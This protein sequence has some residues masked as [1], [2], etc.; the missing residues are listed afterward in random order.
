[1]P[2]GITTSVKSR[3]MCSR[4]PAAGPAH[5]A[6]FGCLAAR[7]SPRPCQQLGAAVADARRHRRLDHQHA[8]VRRARPGCRSSA[9]GAGAVAEPARQAGPRRGA[10]TGAPSCLRRVRSTASRWPW[11]C[12]AEAVHHGSGRARCPCPWAWWCRTVR[13]RAASCAGAS[14][15]TPV[16]ETVTSTY[17]PG[18]TSA[19]CSGIGLVDP[20]ARWRFSMR[21]GAPP[22]G[23]A[24]R[25]FR[26]QVQDRRSPAGAGSACAGH[27][28]AARHGQ[29]EVD[30]L[31]AG[32]R[33]RRLSM[34]ASSWWSVHRLRL[35][36]LLAC[37]SQQALRERGPALR[38]PLRGHLGQVAAAPAGRPAVISPAGRRCPGSPSAGC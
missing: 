38:R 16:S 14:C 18:F 6:P 23:M 15:H 24:S 27:S 30:V 13:R 19:C 9:S 26:H 37:K 25:A 20:A 5:S 21:Q 35:Q 29:F 28:P 32:V 4:G 33:R 10:G 3:S 34:P 22:P 36:R 2:P 1:M 31:A 7:G 17:W 8:L 11:D 12:L